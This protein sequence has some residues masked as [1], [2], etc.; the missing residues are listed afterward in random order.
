MVIQCYAKI[1]I[2]IGG[3]RNKKEW[4]E[5]KGIEDPIEL[6]VIYIIW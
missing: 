4:N 6:R 3:I 2:C 1:I 5:G